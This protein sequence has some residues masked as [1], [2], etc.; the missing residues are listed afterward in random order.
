MG[1]DLLLHECKERRRVSI[2]FPMLEGPKGMRKHKRTCLRWLK[3]Q[4]LQLKHCSSG[5]HQVMMTIRIDARELNEAPQYV[6]EVSCF[7][8][9]TSL[10][11]N[12]PCI[13]CG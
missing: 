3:P 1:R 6:P 5:L 12:L 2:D 13:E 4:G 7:R 11:N 10:I 8:R 9:H